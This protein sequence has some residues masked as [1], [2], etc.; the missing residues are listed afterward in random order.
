MT[1]GSVKGKYR[2]EILDAVQAHPDDI[3]RLLRAK[4]G[5]DL[6]SQAWPLLTPDGLEK[7]RG[8]TS[9]LRSRGW[10]RVFAKSPLFTAARAAEHFLREIRRR[11]VRPKG[12]FVSV[13]GPDGV[14]KTTFINELQTEIQRVLVKDADAVVVRHFRPNILPNIKQ[15]LS[16][17]SYDP[18]SEAFHEPHRA[19]PAGLLGSLVRLTYYWLDYVAGYWLVTRR[20][21]IAGQV[22]VFDRYFYDIVVDPRRSRL[23]LPGWVRRAFLALTPKP[24]LVFFLNCDSATIYA[25]KQE[26]TPDEIKRQLEVYRQLA[27]ADPH[28]FV[29]LDALRPPA[30]SAR[31]AVKALVE[32]AFRP[33]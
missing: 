25:R 8:L 28:R 6:A 10:T 1:G 31:G 23:G 16:G 24:D 3:K 33:L 27:E 20:R 4:F 2:G 21:C 17:G 11:A 32:H 9:A 13:A 29:C 26:L 12:S 15:L 14:G 7:T 5:E 22:C 18:S 30:D 19:P